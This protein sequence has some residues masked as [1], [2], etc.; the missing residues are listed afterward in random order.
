MRRR[1]Q[2][3]GKS[4]MTPQ[5]LYAGH[6]YGMMRQSELPSDRKLS[7]QRLVLAHEGVRTHALSSD[8]GVQAWTPTHG[9]APGDPGRSAVGRRMSRDA[10]RWSNV[11]TEDR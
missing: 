2:S 9:S 11:S 10:E 4:S 5:R 7:D 6:P 1:G 8:R 3:A